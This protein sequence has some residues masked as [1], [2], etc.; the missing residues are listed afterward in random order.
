MREGLG[1]GEGVDEGTLWWPRRRR[2]ARRDR[3]AVVLPATGGGGVGGTWLLWRRK[4]CVGTGQ[5]D[6]SSCDA[7]GQEESGAMRHQGGVEELQR[8]EVVFRER[9][10]SAVREWQSTVR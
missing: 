5:E 2:C 8:E 10:K 6:S 4:D 9:K 1:D 3:V 7:M